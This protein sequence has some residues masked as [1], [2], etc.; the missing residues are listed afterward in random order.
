MNRTLVSETTAKIGEEVL[1]KGWVNTRRDHG[2]IIFID[3]RDKTGLVQVVFVDSQKAKELRPEW[4]VEVKGVVKQ[5]PEKLINPRLGT[6]KIE[7][8]AKELNI[9]AKSEELPFDTGSEELNVSLP[10]LL[11][12]RPLSLRHPRNRAVFKVQE[13]IIASFREVLREE[14]F[15]EIQVPTIV[16]SITE[17][18]AQVF[19]IKYFDK[20][21]FLAQSPQLYKQIMVGVFERVFTLAHAY[22]AEPSVTTRHVTEYVGLDAEM[23]FISSFEDIMDTVEK[24]IRRIFVNLEKENK[25]ELSMF[26]ATIPKLSSKIPRIKMREAQEIIF[27]R[28]GRDNRNEPDLEPE[29]EREICRYSMEEYGS[30]LVFITHYPT[31]KRPFYTFPDPKDP[32]YTE[33]FDLIGRGLEWVTGGRR[34]NDYEMLVEHIKK[35][36]NR[37]EDFEIY[38]QAFK[39]GMPPEGGFCLGAE[40]ITMQVLGLE[41]VREASLFP[42]DMERI[43]LK[44]PKK[45]E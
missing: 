30:E 16:P 12:F 11:D 38:L 7:I 40:R 32:E 31:K 44:L 45:E 13:T 29:D 35:W 5:R 33:S 27:R 20:E 43:D 8:E 26:N 18:G 37:P 41:N 4:V 25:E 22:R 9:L 34:I 39:Y 15:T 6:G 1:V 24:V 36:G 14:S 10:V 19:K 28:T 17:G 2:K 42:R 23:G 3:L 21:A